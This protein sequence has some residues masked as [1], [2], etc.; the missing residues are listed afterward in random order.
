MKLTYE[1]YGVAISV[2]CNKDG[3]P[4]N[5]LI[6]YIRGLLLMAGFHINT[7]NEYIPEEGSYEEMD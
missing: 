5:E 1:A 6:G 2:E 4:M 7:I 3:L